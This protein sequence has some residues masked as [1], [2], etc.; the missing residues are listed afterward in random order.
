MNSTAGENMKSLHMGCG[1]CLKSEEGPA[2][3][4][5]TYKP[6]LH[7]KDSHSF[8]LQEGSVGVFFKSSP[9]EL[10]EDEQ[11]NGSS[12]IQGSTSSF[13]PSSEMHKSELGPPCSLSV[14]ELYDENITSIT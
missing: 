2:I 4:E 14:G 10:L 3:Q 12:S 11:D 7:R 13:F 5:S 6:P 1:D 8:T 9:V